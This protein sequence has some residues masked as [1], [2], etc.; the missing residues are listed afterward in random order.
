MSVSNF[1]DMRF[2]HNFKGLDLFEF[3]KFETHWDCRS[4]RIYGVRCHT[5]SFTIAE[6]HLPCSYGKLDNR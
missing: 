5:A 1:K 3:L 4:Y 6:K 2:R